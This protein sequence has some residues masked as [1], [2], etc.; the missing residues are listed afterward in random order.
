MSKKI[1]VISSSPRRN[2]N[3][4]VLCNQFIQGA[5]K[6]GHHVEKINLNDYKINPC[7]ACA[8]CRKHNNQCFQKDDANL[9]IQK[10]IEADVWVLSSPVY[11]YS[12]TAQMKLLI[13]RF[14]AREFEIR[15]SNKRKQVYYILTSGAPDLTDFPG[16][17]ES[18]KGFVKVLRTVDEV[19]YINGQGAFNL[20]DANNHLAFK[21]AYKIGLEVK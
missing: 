10:M 3:S 17:L 13:D 19:G 2:G 14:F 9:I 16:A 11:F 7:L 12:I 5:N 1:I 18:L 21:Q 8:Y 15:K 20:G 6:A 4:E